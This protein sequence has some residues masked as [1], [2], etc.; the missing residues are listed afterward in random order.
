MKKNVY[1][2]LA[3]LFAIVVAVPAFQSCDDDDDDPV[4]TIAIDKTQTALLDVGDEV[5]A[6]ITIVSAEVKS[7]TYSKVIDNENSTPVDVLANLT[8]VGNTYTYN[9]SYTIVEND[10]LHTLGFEFVI[11]DKNDL[12]ETVSL[13]VQTNLSLRSTFVKYDWT[14][15][16]EDHVDW[17]DL[18]T[19]ADAAKT[20]R[21]NEDG[22]YDVD[23]SADFAGSG[24]HFCYWIYKD[25][26]DK[27][28]TIAI[29]RLIRKQLSGDVG[30]DEYYDFR[31]TS[32]DESVMTMWWDLAAFGILDIQR[33]F[34]SQPKGAFQAYGTEE[35]ATAVEALTVLQCST[36]SDNLL[37]IE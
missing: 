4:T 29:V 6:T 11:I 25:T 31:I 15:T 10:D 30:L 8:K 28:D 26:P 37:T 14:I 18:L 17:G 36:V 23:L 20:L 1:Y 2:L 32:A 22:T 12:S 3:L 13:L 16:G 21:F 5:T 27:G 35:M 33:T 7:F 24:H 9:F 34:K 19:D